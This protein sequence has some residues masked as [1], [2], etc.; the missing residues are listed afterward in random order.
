MLDRAGGRAR[1][2]LVDDDPI[3]R[4]L[5]AEQLGELGFRV[6][7]AFDAASAL[8]MAAVPPDVLV[9]DLSMPG[10]DGFALI[11][12]MHRRYPLVPAILVTGYA[13]DAASSVR[14]GAARGDFMLLQKP[15][16][17]AQLVECISTSLR[18]SQNELARQQTPTEPEMLSSTQA[19]QPTLLP[20][21][22]MLTAP[23]S[24]LS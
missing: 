1:I 6:T 2:L 19:V 7:Q 18:G 20:S 11:T 4:E 13:G 24:F 22:T 16:R 12:E 9:T 14:C 21:T 3:V 15:L 10:M 8:S 5:L 23:T 17:T